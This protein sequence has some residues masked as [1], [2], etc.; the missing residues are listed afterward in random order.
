[1]IHAE[2]TRPRL[3]VAIRLA[4]VVFYAGAGVLHLRSPD[5]FLPIV[6]LWVPAPREVVVLTGLC[7]L[8][9]A[10]GLLVPRLRGLAGI[11]LALYA[12]CVLPANIR[13]AVEGIDIPGLPSSWWYH[14]PRLALQP[15][16]VWAALYGGGVIAWP[17]R[18]KAPRQ[19]APPSREEGGPARPAASEADDSRRL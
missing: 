5:A 19:E 4:M 17:F 18:R 8:A 12:V 6:P 1:M 14:A 7:E 16:L 10:A 13:H 15:V 9:G 3:R 11:M 2:T